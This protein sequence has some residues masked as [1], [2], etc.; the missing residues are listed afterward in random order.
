MNS[1]YEQKYLKYKEKYVALKNKLQGGSS[2]VMSS[3]VQ[4]KNRCFMD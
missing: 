4:K 3:G 2:G 1:S